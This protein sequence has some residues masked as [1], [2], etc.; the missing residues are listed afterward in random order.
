VP[1]RFGFMTGGAQGCHQPL[2]HHAVIVA[3]HYFRHAQN[4]ASL[5]LFSD[6]T[7]SVAQTQVNSHAAP[8][9]DAETRVN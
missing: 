2:G 4:L 6:K 5:Q 8:A 3:N 1:A 9:G 7:Q